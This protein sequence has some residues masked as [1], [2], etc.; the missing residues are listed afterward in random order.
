MTVTKERIVRRRATG[1][2][3]SARCAS[4]MSGQPPEASNEMANTERG[5]EGAAWGDVPVRTAYA[6]VAVYL[7]AAQDCLLAM[8]DSVNLLTTAYVPSVLARAAMEAS[9]QA[10]WLLERG[11]GARRRVIRS[12]LIRASGARKLGEAVRKTDP[13]GSASSYGEDQARVRAYAR[14]LGLTYICNDDR[15]ECEIDALPSPTSRATALE[16][17]MQMV[18]AYKIYSGAAHAE[19]HSVVQ[20]WRQAPSPDGPRWQRQPDREAVWAMVLSAAGLATMP[21]FRTLTL[22]GWNARLVELSYSMRKLDEM[23][24]RMKLPHEWAY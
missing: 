6:E 8:A 22:L 14:N 11:I 3:C 18:A 1:L 24:R 7:L 12:V 20:G 13:R 17:A 5:H 21:A 4:T 15:I 23:T 2:S 16:S 19:W 9:G 10:W